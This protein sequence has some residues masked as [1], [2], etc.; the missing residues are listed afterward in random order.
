MTIKIYQAK[1]QPNHK[2]PAREQ[3]DLEESENNKF[4]VKTTKDAKYFLK[5]K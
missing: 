2:G 5:P 3:Q 4:K 1:S